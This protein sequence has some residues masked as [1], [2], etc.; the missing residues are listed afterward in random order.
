M[1]CKAGAGCAPCWGG[2][3]RCGGS[4]CP[5]LRTWD[6]EPGTLSPILGQSPGACAALASGHTWVLELLRV[7][8]ASLS[9]A[10]DQPCYKRGTED[11]AVAN[12]NR[13]QW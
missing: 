13:K 8:R 11:A 3:P 4:P 10:R 9:C 6:S 7:F 12:D 1:D 5:G 2:Q